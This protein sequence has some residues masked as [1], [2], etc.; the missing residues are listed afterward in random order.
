MRRPLLRPSPQQPTETSRLPPPHIGQNHLTGRNEIPDP[1]QVAAPF[2]GMT[3]PAI[4]NIPPRIPPIP[5]HTTR[6][7]QFDEPLFETQRI[8]REL[9]RL[10]ISKPFLVPIAQP[11]ARL[12]GKSIFKVPSDKEQTVRHL[13][14]PR[15]LSVSQI[16]N[17]DEPANGCAPHHPVLKESSSIRNIES[18]PMIDGSRQTGKGSH[19]PVRNESPIQV[20]DVNDMGQIRPL[21]I[22]MV[23]VEKTIDELG[24]RLNYVLS[25]I[26]PGFLPIL[27]G[28]DDGR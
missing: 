27:L 24:Y 15:P 5:W 28:V 20:D 11:T 12:I 23:R 10:P 25:G 14:F 22:R 18:V 3:T 6:L 9:H 16:G 4:H 2:Q 13:P 17:V 1:I 19:Q 26:F 7:V 21:V 8:R